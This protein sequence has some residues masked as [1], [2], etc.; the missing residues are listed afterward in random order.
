MVRNLSLQELTCFLAVNLPLLKVLLRH[1]PIPFVLNVPVYYWLGGFLLQVPGNFCP[2]ALSAH[3]N[4]HG[5]HKDRLE[6]PM[7]QQPRSSIQQIINKSLVL[8]IFS[9]LVSWA[10]AFWGLLFE[11]FQRSLPKWRSSNPQ[12]QPVSRTFVDF[13]PFPAH[14]SNS[15]LWF[16]ELHHK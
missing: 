16:L 3:W 15:L 1:L 7:N 9:F 2:R 4:W 14:F 10:G 13:L 11:V 6:V 8:K 12:C 5:S